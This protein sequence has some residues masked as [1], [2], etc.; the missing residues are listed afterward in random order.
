MKKTILSS[1]ILITLFAVNSFAQADNLLASNLTDG[2][3][4][5][6]DTM[7]DI[8]T[9]DVSDVNTVKNYEIPVA[10]VSFEMNPSTNVID[11]D[12]N[13]DV[14]YTKAEL[15]SK[16]S[17]E[18]VQSLN[19]DEDNQSVDISQINSGTYYL[20]LSNEEGK[21]YSEKLIIL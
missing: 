19:I 4:Y 8:N 18:T 13:N 20:I 7:D 12:I 1:L 11:I 6:E 10:A 5:F 16:D 21:V 3:S 9:I 17:N 15:L 14:K 2:P